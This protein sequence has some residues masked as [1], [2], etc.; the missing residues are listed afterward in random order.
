[1]T[2]K[3][4][5]ALMDKAVEVEV[6]NIWICHSGGLRLHGTLGPMGL[7]GQLFRRNSIHSGVVPQISIVLGVVAGGLTWI[8]VDQLTETLCGISRPG[9]FRGVTAVCT[10]LFNIVQPDKAFFGQKDVQQALVIE[11]IRYRMGRYLR[12][13]RKNNK[14]RKLD[15]KTKLP[16]NPI[17]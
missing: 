9:H 10:K 12:F 11:R 7:F 16:I 14:S 4:I 1:M 17:R 8:H 6:I 5:C 15:F 3:K 2:D 13:I